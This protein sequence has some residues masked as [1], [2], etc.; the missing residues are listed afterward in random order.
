ML[1]P[2]SV[3][4]S[5]TI[6]LLSRVQWTRPF[7]ILFVTKKQGCA[8]SIFDWEVGRVHASQWFTYLS[9]W[10]KGTLFWLPSC[11]GAGEVKQFLSSEWNPEKCSKI[12][13]ITDKRCVLNCCSLIRCGKGLSWFCL[14]IVIGEMTSHLTLSFVQTALGQFGR[15]WYVFVAQP[16]SPTRLN[17]SLLCRSRNNWNGLPRRIVQIWGIFC[18]PGPLKLVLGRVVICIRQVIE[19]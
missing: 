18:L 19:T 8:L 9:N 14:E 12:P 10:G 15:S 1:L 2:H 17:T 11:C 16:W 7:Q 6:S 3:S 13:R 5:H 4:Q